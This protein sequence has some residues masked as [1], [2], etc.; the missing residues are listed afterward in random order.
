MNAIVQA[1]EKPNILL[2]GVELKDLQFKDRQKFK[3]YNPIARPYMPANL[4]QELVKQAKP[5]VVLMRQPSG[6]VYQYSSD[7]MLVSSIELEDSRVT[8]MAEKQQGMSALPRRVDQFPIAEP[9]FV[10]GQV[11]MAF[12][13][14]CPNRAWMRMANPYPNS[15]GQATQPMA[16]SMQQ[17]MPPAQNYQMLANNMQMQSMPQ[18]YPK[19]VAPQS[20]ASTI[21]RPFPGANVP[22]YLYPGKSEYSYLP[23]EGTP[24]APIAT[25]VAR[26][27]LKQ[28]ATLVQNTSYPF[29]FDSY[30]TTNSDLSSLSS[31]SGTNAGFPTLQFNSNT[32]ASGSVVASQWLG[33]GVGLGASLLDSALES[34]Q[35]RRQAAAADRDANGTMNYYYPGS[36][37]TYYPSTPYQP[38]PT[39]YG[40]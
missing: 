21:Q 1:S 7:G 27:A 33:T 24:R 32:T 28:A 13:I 23:G 10:P 18:V 6:G 3:D 36:A 30:L 17:Q 22:N 34:A 26:Q 2:I 40:Y 16:Y 12:P 15:T 35:I 14:Y 9:K 11:V 19:Y 5:E 29:W 31:A 20:N 8:Q 38:L 4:V 37:S 39:N 25:S